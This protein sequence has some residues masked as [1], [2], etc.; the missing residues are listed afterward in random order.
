MPGVDAFVSVASH[1][2]VETF[3]GILI[4]RFD[5][6]LLFFN[7]DRFK[8][9]LREIVAETAPPPRA[10]V[11]SAET[12]VLVDT[13]GTAVLADLTQELRGRGIIVAIADAK[14]AVRRMLERTGVDH[15][16]GADRFYRTV[17]AAVD[18]LLSKGRRTASVIRDRPSRRSRSRHTPPMEAIE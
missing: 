4:Y 13:T 9:R 1:P 3:P 7:A 18:A 6:A 2:E 16:I 17:G 14:T 5:A 11:I 8:A 15:Q 10:V 12:I